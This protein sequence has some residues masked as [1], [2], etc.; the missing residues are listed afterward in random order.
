M[1]SEVIPTP[2]LKKISYPRFA[3]FYN[4]MIGHPLVRRMFDPLRRETAGHTHGVVLEVSAGAGQNFPFYDSTRVVRVEAVEPGEAMLAAAER[5]LADAPIP[6][7]LSRAP[8]EA[9]RSQLHSL[10]VRWR[11]LS[12][13]LCRIRRAACAKS[14]TCLSRAARCC[15]SNMC[16]G[17]GRSYPGSRMCWC[18]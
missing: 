9:P 8:V 11:R 2:G 15:S 18:H 6:I 3:A 12:S 17:K 13:V 4:R 1:S 5:S 14:G 16:V 7:R 10:I